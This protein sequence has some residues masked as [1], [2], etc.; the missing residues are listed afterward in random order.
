MGAAFLQLL[1]IF[2]FLFFFFSLA[3]AFLKLA[4]RGRKP[5][6]K[7]LGRAEVEVTCLQNSSG[8]THDKE[9]PPDRVFSCPFL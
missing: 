3:F 4:S 9:F 8:K 2:L 7:T 5:F 1:Q 6:K